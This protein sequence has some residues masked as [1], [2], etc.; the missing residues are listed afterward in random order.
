MVIDTLYFILSCLKAQELGVR[1]VTLRF[2][3]HCSTNGATVLLIGISSVVKAAE[4][5]FINSN[6]FSESAQFIV[7]HTRLIGRVLKAFH[8]VHVN[9]AIHFHCPCL[10]YIFAFI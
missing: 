6:I 3:T 5:R 9:I 10:C 1:H 2:I 4:D 8:C 7:I